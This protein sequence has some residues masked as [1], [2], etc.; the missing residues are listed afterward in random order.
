ML[1]VGGG[2]ETDTAFN[3]TTFASQP[4]PRSAQQ[5]FSPTFERAR[6][7]R[8]FRRQVFI[9]S[10]DKLAQQLA[11]KL[12]ERQILRSHGALALMKP[13]AGS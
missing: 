3:F 11:L 2:T 12:K 7:C 13:A 5:F 10:E 4:L 8:Q 9:S 6:A 1:W